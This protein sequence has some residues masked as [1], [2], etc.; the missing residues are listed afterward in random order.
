MKFEVKKKR[1]KCYI[2]RVRIPKNANSIEKSQA[3]PSLRSLSFKKCIHSNHPSLLLSS[4]S[5]TSQNVNE[6]DVVRIHATNQ[7]NTGVGTALHAHG[8]F[9]NQT[10]Y[11]D[12]AVGITQCPIPA[13]STFTY[14]LLNSPSSPADRQKQW[15]TYWIH[16]HFAGQY[17]DGLRAPF[18][19]HPVQQADIFHTY[20]E[21][22]TVILGDW[23][24]RNHTDL[25]RNEFLNDKNPTGVSLPFH[26]SFSDLFSRFIILRYPH[27]ITHITQAEPVPESGLMYFARTNSS[28]PQAEYVPGYNE[29]ATISFV[30]GRTYRLRLIN[31]SALSMFNFWIDG[32]D[33]RI[34]EVDGVDVDEFATD[35][36]PISVAQVSSSAV[37]CYL[38]R[39]LLSL[40][41]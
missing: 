4:S 2:A 40:S 23:Y 27:S 32:H 6:T 12:G 10:S 1:L 13:S 16:G 19:V 15:G 14:E 9:F 11:F 38:F 30:P 41:D 31:T 33:M 25:L 20:D 36:V 7:L 35:F 28:S 24:H 39:V 21:D 17:V 8:Q 29:N 26:L 18:I 34:I 5:S 3:K 22:Y 37:F